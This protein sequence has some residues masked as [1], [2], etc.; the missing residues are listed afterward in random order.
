MIECPALFLGYGK[1]YFDIF[2]NYTDLIYIQY[3]TPNP[4]S[5]NPEDLKSGINEKLNS[6]NYI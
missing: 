3:G 6:K 1:H 4:E 5:R 2:L